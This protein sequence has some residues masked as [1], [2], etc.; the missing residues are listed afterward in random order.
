M[1]RTLPLEMKVSQR[2]GRRSVCAAAS[3]GRPRRP[4]AEGGPSFG[5]NGD[6]DGEGQ[7]AAQ[8]DAHRQQTDGEVRG[9]IPVARRDVAHGPR[10]DAGRDR[11]L[12]RRRP[13]DPGRD[14][15]AER[16]DVIEVAMQDALRKR[17]ARAPAPPAA[18]APDPDQAAL[19]SLSGAIVGSCP[20]PVNRLPHTAQLRPDDP[21][22]SSMAAA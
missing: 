9:V 4:Q 5:L 22:I 13:S 17:A 1:P 20:Q 21:T 6:V 7:M 2:Q 16:V 8:C 14:D 18:P 15:P 3:G 11:D 12:A 10:R 19:R